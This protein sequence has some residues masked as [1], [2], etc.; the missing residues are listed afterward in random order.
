MIRI[1]LFN[2][3]LSANFCAF[4]YLFVNCSPIQPKEESLPLDKNPIHFS[5]GQ[6]WVYKQMCIFYG[7][8][9]D[10]SYTNI[11]FFCFKATKDTTIDS[12]DYIIIES[13]HLMTDSAI[14]NEIPA[15]FAVYSCDTGLFYYD[16]S[17]DANSMF[18]TAFNMGL[19][20]KKNELGDIQQYPV[21]SVFRKKSAAMAVSNLASNHF[22]A[23]RFP[24]IKDSCWYYHGN[25]GAKKS[26]VNLERINANGKMYSTY[27]LEWSYDA[28]ILDSISPDTAIAYDWYN[29]I[30]LLK[31]YCKCINIP[32]LD[33]NGTVTD[34]LDSLIEEISYIGDSL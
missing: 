31:R 22:C 5:V 9:K 33:T 27:K 28:S 32:S 29:D 7:L 12:L 4:L 16:I 34:T 25:S 2:F 6:T 19:L 18:H 20:K 26:F 21:S 15:R 8:V 1:I 30:G 13:S 3:Y 14:I 10:T 24:I 23:I 17:L 11:T